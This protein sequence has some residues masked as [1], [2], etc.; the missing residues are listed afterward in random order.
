MLTKREFLEQKRHNFITFLESKFLKNH[1]ILLKEFQ[2]I[3]NIPIETLLIYIS[4]KLVPMKD[5]LDKLV[6]EIFQNQGLDASDFPQEDIDKL[7]LYF[8]C[9]IDCVI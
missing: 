6:V 5:N 1:P 3:K 4:E 2:Q 8:S 9:F 7:K